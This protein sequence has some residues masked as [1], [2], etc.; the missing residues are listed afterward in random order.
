MGFDS[1]RDVWITTS[2]FI[3]CLTSGEVSG[4]SIRPGEFDSR[5][6]YHLRGANFDGEVLPLKQREPISSMGRP[7]NMDKTTPCPYPGQVLFR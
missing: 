6:G 5:T 2:K 4:L 7:T 1:L 3:S